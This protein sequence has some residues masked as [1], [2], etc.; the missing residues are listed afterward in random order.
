MELVSTASRDQR[1]ASCSK[2]TSQFLE[3]NE[4]I[5]LWLSSIQLER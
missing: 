2:M 4:V 1:D 3:L 5:L